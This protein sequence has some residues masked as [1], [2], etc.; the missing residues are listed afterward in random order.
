MITADIFFSQCHVYLFFHLYIDIVVNDLSN[1]YISEFNAS[2][3]YPVE[4]RKIF[5]IHFNLENY[6]TPEQIMTIV[7][8]KISRCSFCWYYSLNICPIVHNVW[9]G[10]MLLLVQCKNFR[11]KHSSCCDFALTNHIYIGPRIDGDPL[12]THGY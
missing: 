7:I 12:H 11:R 9:S 5:F 4:F 1:V 10:S 2:L 6:R 8:K 3:V